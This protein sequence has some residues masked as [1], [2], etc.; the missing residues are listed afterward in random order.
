MTLYFQNITIVLL[1]L[2]AYSIFNFEKSKHKSN[3]P[4]RI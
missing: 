2:A 3:L 1:N 4:V